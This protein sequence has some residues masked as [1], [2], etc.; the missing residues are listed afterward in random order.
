MRNLLVVLAWL[1]PLAVLAAPAQQAAAARDTPDGYALRQPIVLQGEAPAYRVTIPASVYDFSRQEGLRDLR[2]FN[3]AGE[4]VPFAVDVVR[5][6]AND[7][8]NQQVLPFFAVPALAAEQVTQDADGRLLLQKTVSEKPVGLLLDASQIPSG[9]WQTLTLQLADANYRG[10]VQ[11]LLSDDLQVWRTGGQQELLK[12]ASG[13]G[14]TTVNLDGQHARYLR[15]DW[16]DKPFRLQAATLRWRERG[17]APAALNWTGW[18][19]ARPGPSPGE[20]L[21]DLGLRAPFERLDIR[22]PQANTVAGAQWY[23]RESESMPW[24][25][26]ASSRLSQLGQASVALQGFGSVPWRYW[27]L[28][29][30]TQ[31]GGLGQGM[32]ELRAAWPTEQLTFIARG[33]APFLLACGRETPGAAPQTLDALFDGKA[34]QLASASLAAPLPAA[35]SST[36]ASAIPPDSDRWRKA[37]LWGS[38]LLAVLLL[39]AMAWKV[40]REPAVGQGTEDGG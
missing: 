12:L 5:P 21:F 1:V 28:L 39:G 3:A 18:Q 14:Q 31:Q 11:W 13:P 34:V 35:A 29:V 38:L 19:R 25:A 24:Q 32:P 26:I 8:E 16:L 22:L 6:S 9:Q 20:Y 23:S 7:R 33:Q 2:V 17:D 27:R 10:R 40:L 15:L 30:D 36:A 37:G 4:P